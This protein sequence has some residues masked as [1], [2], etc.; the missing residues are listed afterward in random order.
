MRISR[1]DGRAVSLWTGTVSRLYVGEVLQYRPLP[2]R[3][4]KRVGSFLSAVHHYLELPFRR[5][6]RGFTQFNFAAKTVISERKRI[7]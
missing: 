3:R 1:R 6:Q 4:V 7:L 2:E 5:P